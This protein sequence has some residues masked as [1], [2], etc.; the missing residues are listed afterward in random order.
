M[1]ERKTEYIHIKVT[2]EFKK[3][4]QDYCDATGRTIT[5]LVEW[6]LKKEMEKAAKE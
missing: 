4:V 2:P 6:L 5:S 1:T 3:Q